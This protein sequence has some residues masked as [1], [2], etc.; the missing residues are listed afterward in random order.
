[1]KKN[2]NIVFVTQYFPPDVTAA[3]FRISETA[4]ILK[5]DGFNVKILTAVPHKLIRKYDYIKDDFKVSRVPI[6]RLGGQETKDYLIH[7]LSFMITSLLWGIC[8]IRSKIDCI[9]ATSPPLFVAFSGW[10]LARI[11]NAKFIL[12]VRDI[13]PDS[14]VA[15]GHLR[16]FSLLYRVTKLFEYSIYRR[17]DLI[18]CVSEKMKDYIR[19]H[20]IRDMP[21]LVLYNGLFLKFFNDNLIRY[22]NYV[23]SQSEFVISYIG[24]IGYA[25]NLD[26]LINVAKS[27]KDRNIK[28]TLIGDGAVKHILMDKV[29][30]ARLKNVVFKNACSKK[31][32]FEYMNRSHALL[33]IL[34]KQYSAFNLTIPSKVF[35]YLWSN[36]PILFGIEGEGKQILRSLPGNLYFDANN[37]IS[38]TEAI[39]N[40]KKNY[41]HYQSEANKNRAFVLN[42]FTREKITK[43]LEE[44]LL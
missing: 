38:L 23:P 4:V 2:K 33:I 30:S 19:N 17:A 24:N 21:I 39:A 36:K 15:T 11:K 32:S 35:D 29:A 43:K 40:L 5:D 16:A 44:Y 13:W 31:E 9:I 10:L 7:Y 25:Q 3:A 20:T 18:T 6:L 26:L 37:P 34:N 42:N 12:D 28:F 1:M 22:D 41:N 14:A 8:K 27:Y